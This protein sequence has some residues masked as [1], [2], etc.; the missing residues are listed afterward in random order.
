MNFI[1]KC[2]SPLS[3]KLYKTNYRF[4]PLYAINIINQL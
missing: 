3:Y 4:Y 1:D 2:L